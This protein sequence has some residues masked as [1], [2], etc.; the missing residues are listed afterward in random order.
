MKLLTVLTMVLPTRKGR[1]SSLSGVS[2]TILRSTYGVHMP[3]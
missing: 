3:S 1:A 2:T